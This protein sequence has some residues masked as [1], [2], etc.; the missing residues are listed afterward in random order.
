[1]TLFKEQEIK[2]PNFDAIPEEL[3]KHPKW[4]VWKAIHQPTE[5]NPE[6]MG[7]VP[8]YLN[9]KPFAKWKEP[10]S[11]STFEQVKEA[12]ET[13]KFDGVGIIFNRSDHLVCADLDDFEDINNIPAEKYDLTLHSYTEISPSGSGLHIWIIGQKPEW[14]KT[15]KNGVEFFGDE[16][17]TF[18]TVTGDV[19]HKKDPMLSH[20]NVYEQQGLIDMI[21][22]KYFTKPENDDP[23]NEII[24]SEN[25][26]T[27]DEV[28]E[29]ALQ[30]NLTKTLFSGDYSDYKTDSRF[31]QSKGDF[32]LCCDFAKF[33][34]D[35][36]QIVRL[37]KKSGLYRKPPLKHET[38]PKRTADQALKIMAKTPTQEGQAMQPQE[39]KTSVVN[40]PADYYIYNKQGQLKFNIHL[41]KNQILDDM[42]IFRSDIGILRYENGVYK[43]SLNGDIKH[44]IQSRIKEEATKNRKDEIL[45]L[46]VHEHEAIPLSKFNSK[47]KIL[48]LKNGIYNIA[49]GSFQPHSKEYLWTIQH[50]VEYDPEAECPAILEFLH[51]VLDADSVEF[52]IEWI[53]HMMLP[54]S[55]TD[56]MVFLYGLGGNGKGV[57]INII[58]NLIGVLNISNMSLNDLEKDQFSR[59]HLYGKLSNICGDIDNRIIKNTGIIKSLT[60]GDF[61]YAQFKGIDGFT[62]KS[63]AKLMFSAN[64][65]PMTT[66]KTDGWFRRM[67]I[68]PF[69]KKVPE[70]K[71]ISRTELDK[72]LSSPEELSGL[73]N[74]V[75]K[76]IHKLEGNGYRFTVSQAAQTALEDYMYA[77]D[78]LQQFITQEGNREGRET[79]KQFY[80]AY[81]DWCEENGM[82]SEKRLKIKNQLIEKGF[83]V[84]VGTGN[85]E[86]VFG[87]SFSESSCYC[88]SLKRVR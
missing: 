12:Y 24:V 44:I 28:L 6:R 66:D 17:N 79:M 23:E 45:D 70:E 67:F 41:V 37:F 76:A 55:D 16:A 34:K 68:L 33:T 82:G 39:G 8:C 5:E 11:W 51:D 31:D 59:A 88:G 20:S 58:I 77:N 78:K 2:K 47:H 36:N 61:V 42:P 21:A 52:L 74:L 15:K 13:G 83:I 72:K 25:T 22:N 43:R 60:G 85:K 84:E 50:P 54:H 64:E 49:D 4:M 69:N 26:L 1:M 19:F 9:G 56:R 18:V 71:R 40:H 35:A 29:R 48:N 14:C 80:A 57:L 46:I 10:E 27:D 86:Y 30:N 62:F 65:L 75:I 32:A 81:Q 53:A 7:K 73:L 87:F 3:K 38:Y 63:F